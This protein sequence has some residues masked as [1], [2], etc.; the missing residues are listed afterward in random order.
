MYCKEP[1]RTIIFAPPTN[2]DWTMSIIL[3][4]DTPPS[5][6]EATAGKQNNIN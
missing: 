4:S 1:S 3:K 6:A 2:G 5:F